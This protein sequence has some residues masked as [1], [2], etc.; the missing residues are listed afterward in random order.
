MFGFGKKK[1]DK[2]AW[3]TAVFEQPVS[4]P[5]KL[6]EKEL[7]GMTGMM[8]SQYH[9]IIMESFG[10]IQRT[11]NEDTRQGRIDL[12]Q[13]NYQKMQRWEPFA[14]EDQ[15]AIIRECQ[16]ALQGINTQRN[17]GMTWDHL[18]KFYDEWSQST[19]VQRIS[20]LKDYGSQEE[21]VEVA[22]ATCDEKAASKLI[23]K[24]IESGVVFSQDNILDL[25]GIVDW[26]T[27]QFAVL[28]TLKRGDKFKYDDVADLDGLV[29]TDTLSA[30]A[31]AVLKTGISLTADQIM[32]W[33]GIV[34]TAVLNETVKASHEYFEPDDLA[35]LDGIVDHDILVA[36]DKRQGTMTFDYEDALEE[37]ETDHPGDLFKAVAAFGMFAQAGKKPSQQRFRIGDH[38]RVKYRGQEGT[39]EDI[40]GSLYMVS[41][42]DDR[43]VDSYPKSQ[44]EKAW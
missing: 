7:R 19:L 44:L 18:Y 3:A 31:R 40:N 20:L 25:D 12:C 27:I 10:I 42:D 23:R 24:A 26:E 17:N 16:T 29:D 14:D 4:N 37:D 6:S 41:L 2:A 43:R 33:D 5:E 11:K 1:V 39:I 21:V 15:L 34:D 30:V 28:Q 22:E 8:L 13:K 9:R 38:M 32:E 36:I 35:A